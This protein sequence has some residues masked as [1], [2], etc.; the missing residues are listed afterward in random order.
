MIKR[1]TKITSLLVCAASIMSIVP[2]MA[3]DIKSY[4]IFRKS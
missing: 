4:Y 3:A 2:A 1:M